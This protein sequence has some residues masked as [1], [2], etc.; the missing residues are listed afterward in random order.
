MSE[1]TMLMKLKLLPNTFKHAK[2]PRSFYEARKIIT[3]LGLRYTNIDALSY[4]CM[5]YFREDKDIDICK[6]CNTSRWKLEKKMEHLMDEKRCL[7]KF[8]GIF[9]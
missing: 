4:D 7:Q 2:I 5:L 1:K 3:K 9:L 6:K 8:Y